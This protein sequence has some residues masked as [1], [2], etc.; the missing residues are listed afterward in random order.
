LLG[1]G[2]I[3]AEQQKTATPRKEETFVISEVEQEQTVSAA[4]LL[5]SRPLPRYA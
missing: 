1:G 3:M 4:R 5:S 2:R